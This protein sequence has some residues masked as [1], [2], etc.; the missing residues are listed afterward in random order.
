MVAKPCHNALKTDLSTYTHKLQPNLRN[1]CKYYF[2]IFFIAVL[3]HDHNP[4][5]LNSHMNS[6][7]IFMFGQLLVTH[8]HPLHRQCISKNF[9][10]S[11]LCFHTHLNCCNKKIM[12]KM[13]I[14]LSCQL[15]FTSKL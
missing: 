13:K 11:K 15:Y 10:S 7:V 1:Q 5:S 9:D 3:L 6:L 8:Q 4:H 2:R 14:F 12:R